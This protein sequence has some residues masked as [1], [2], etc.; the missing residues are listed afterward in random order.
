MK[1]SFVI[2][3]YR[4]EH[5]IRGVVGEIQEV[6]KRQSPNADYEII[7]V[8]D[9]SPDSVF[10]VISELC[11]RDPQHLKGLELARNFGQPSAQMAGFAHTCGDIVVSLDD[12]GQTPVDE[13]FRLVDKLHEGYDVVYGTYPNKKH[14]VFRRIG[15]DINHFMA[16]S[17]IGV[18]KGLHTTSFFVM[19]R[20]VV[21]E[22]LKYV[23]PFPYVGGLVFRITKN[24]AHVDVNHR[25]RIC[26]TSG[27][28]FSRL[29]RLWVNGFTAFSVKPLRV[30]TWAGL[31]C[32]ILGFAG[33]LVTVLRK[34]FV[35]SSVPMGYSSLMCTILFIGGVMMLILGLIG[36]YVGR[37]YI[38]INQAPQYVISRRI[39][40][41]A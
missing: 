14:N 13:V 29:L 37:I 31:A 22:I 17:L 5:T 2:P 3:C 20:Y 34:L 40:I 4:S 7:M 35:D 18:T 15:S 36:E 19:R 38:C 32:A 27:Y 12:D 6:V 24:V 39:N 30:A 28:S 8:S 11:E 10:N 25:D 41:I 9:H 16:V 1:I 23:G 33:G 26:G 21:D